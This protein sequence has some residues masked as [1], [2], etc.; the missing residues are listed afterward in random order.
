MMMRRSKQAL[1]YCIMV[2]MT[3]AVI[4]GMAQAAYYIAYGELN[5]GGP[6]QSRPAVGAVADELEHRLR[7]SG[8]IRHPYYGYTASQAEQSLNQVPPPRREDGVVLIGLLGGSV[9]QDVTG[10][11][12]R[13]LEAWFH[14][15]DIPLRPIVLELAYRMMKQ[16][17][18][19]MV[20]ANTLSLGGEYDI[21]VNLDGYNELIGPNQNYFEHGVSPFYPR[22]WHQAQTDLTNAQQLTLGRI[23]VLRQREQRL[24]AL[25]AADPWRYSAL[26]GIV[27]RYLRERAAGQILALNHELVA[28][29]AGEYNLQRY[30]PALAIGTDDYDLSQ[31][32]LRVWYRGSVMLHN[33]SRTAGAEYYHFQQP[34]QYVPDSKPLTDVELAVAYEPGISTI[35]AYRE[36]YPLLLRLGDEL[37]QQGINYY[38]LTQI[39]ADNRETLYSDRCCHFNERGN[40]LLAASMVQRLAPALRHQAALA[41]RRVRGENST[42]AGAPLYPAAQETL[43]FHVVN[44]LYFDVGRTEGGTLRYSRDSCLPTETASLFFVRVTPADDADL[45]PE[46]AASGYNSYDFSFDRDGGVMDAAGKCVMEY[47]LPEY[48]IARVE[49]GQYI[50]DTGQTLWRARIPFDLGFAVELTPAGALRY[51]RDSCLPAHTAALFFL[52]ITPAD[53]AD[54]PPGRAKYG[55]NNY[56]FPN[57]SRDDRVS[58]ASGRCVMERKLPGYD[59]A[60]ILTGQYI[61]AA[62]RLWETRIDIEQP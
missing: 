52:H 41:T 1:F 16:P 34:N 29:L 45:L 22:F 53:R 20:I 49:T 44:K 9:S 8:D 36:G 59:I 50:P 56:D 23:Y 4:E 30:G 10:A 12:R 14:N 60:S 11:F 15:N 61:I 62:G 46:N 18:Q 7:R 3:L 28:T 2:I 26:Y 42:A 27:N 13:A 19:V 24:G 39:F 54:L 43:P 35:R 47:R 33:L 6:A 31:S 57:F 32:A 51:S 21:I 55:Y 17:Q 48:D 40:E 37:R 38:D 58:E 5:G 25:A